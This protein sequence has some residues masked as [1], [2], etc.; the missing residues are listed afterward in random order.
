VP[1]ADPALYYSVHET[2]TESPLY[3]PNDVA[4]DTDAELRLGHRIMEG[5]AISVFQK[6][7][8]PCAWCSLMLPILLSPSFQRRLFA[9][10]DLSQC[11]P[12]ARS[13]ASSKTAAYVNGVSLTL[14]NDRHIAASFQ[15]IPCIPSHNYLRN[16]T[17]LHYSRKLGD[18]FWFIWKRCILLQFC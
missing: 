8:V 14:A 13:K 5:I 7:R 11:L 18:R 17:C 6:Y 3:P 12:R 2:D 9:S 10:Q 4:S 1:I 15:K 16:F